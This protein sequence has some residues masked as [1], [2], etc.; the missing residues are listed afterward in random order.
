LVL[1]CDFLRLFDKSFQ[2]SHVSKSEKNVKYIFSNTGLC[3]SVIQS[4]SQRSSSLT[5]AS[6]ITA[7]RYRH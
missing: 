4:F 7:H 6:E 1:I 2:K 3:E 5:I